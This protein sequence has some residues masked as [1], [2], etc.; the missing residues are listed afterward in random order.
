MKKYISF[1]RL[2]F[3]LLAICIACWPVLYNGFPLLA[4]DSGTYVLTSSNFELQI[5]RF[6]S[7]GI[8]T[9]LT[10]FRTSL[11]GTALF[12]SLIC[13]WLIYL[14][15]KNVVSVPFNRYVV[16][17]F[18][19][20]V[21]GFS[22]LAWYNAIIMPDIFTGILAMALCIILFGKNSKV[23]KTILYT[24][25]F[26]SIL[27]HNSN[28]ILSLVCSLFLIFAGWTLRRRQIRSTGISTLGISVVVYLIVCSTYALN[29]RGFRFSPSSHMFLISRMAGSGVLD[30]FLQ[31]NCGHSSYRLC[32][33]IGKIKD[34]EIQFLWND[35]D[36]LHKSPPEGWL[37]KEVLDE[38]NTINRQI[39][40]RPR[41]LGA[42]IKNCAEVSFIQLGQFD[43]GDEWDD[44]KSPGSSPYNNMDTYFHSSMR[45]LRAARQQN[46]DINFGRFS[47]L[48]L[49]F[50]FLLSICLLLC[51]VV[52]KNNAVAVNKKWQLIL[53]FMG[54]YYILN[55]VITSSL[56]AFAPRFSAR[57]IWCIC[58]CALGMIGET[59]YNHVSNKMGKPVK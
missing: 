4:Y 7:Y 46:N 53:L 16:L 48:Y 47:S 49:N 35:A 40:S 34:R 41:Y 33:S 10:S 19:L 13:C 21:S 42:F 11:F 27:I 50:Y 2:G 6:F 39:L 25:V 23:E 1:S 38:Y 3:A 18:I 59:M 29:G 26:F 54:L 30:R 14:F 37:S 9:A 56:S 12:Q 17:L 24:V 45:L 43:I 52:N 58:L 5:D 32:E 28:F 15:V 20:I 55:A 57:V 44:F 22:T 51:F 36:Y 8:F 31:D